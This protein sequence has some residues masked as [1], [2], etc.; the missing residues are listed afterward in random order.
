MKLNFFQLRFGLCYFATWLPS[1]RHW[2]EAMPFDDLSSK[3]H[4]HF[5][6]EQTCSEW[7]SFFPIIFGQEVV[8]VLCVKLNCFYLCLWE[9]W[10]VYFS[11]FE[12]RTL[13]WTS[14][15]AFWFLRNPLSAVCVSVC[16]HV[17][18]SRWV[19]I[20]SWSPDCITKY[21]MQCGQVIFPQALLCWYL[22]LWQN[23]YF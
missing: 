10:W 19:N 23:K 8:A 9:L 14:L 12:T 3:L 18:M 7:P 5:S 6:P 20:C 1:V 21:F 11:F 4:N 16:I 15:Q 13:K 2:L 22:M 17:Y